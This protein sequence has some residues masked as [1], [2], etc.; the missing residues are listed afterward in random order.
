L[1]SYVAGVR[2]TATRSN[3]LASLALFGVI[4]G[5]SGDESRSGATPRSPK[6]NGFRELERRLLRLPRVENAANDRP[7][8]GAI[9]LPGIPAE[10]GLGPWPGEAT[11]REGP[12]YVVLLAGPPRVA[13][14]SG[15]L[16]R[17]GR[18]KWRAVATLWVSKPSYNGP[19]LVRGRRLDRPERVA[20]GRDAYP[21]WELRLP[22]GRWSA[23]ATFDV[24]GIAPVNPSPRWRVAASTTR[25]GRLS[26][27]DFH[28]CYAFQ[29]DGIGFSYV[30][31]FWAQRQ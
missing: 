21:R 5:C 4:V 8:A 11:P 12:V 23:E 2:T 22:A 15:E 16:A 13:Y 6:E 31:A 18:S 7:Q 25:V 28:G 20:Y 26:K 14:L 9:S 24:A 30:L 17:I 1:A 19:V 10:G 29:D 3:L 27:P